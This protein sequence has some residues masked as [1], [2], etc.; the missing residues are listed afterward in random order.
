MTAML[1]GNQPNKGRKQSI[2]FEL[3]YS[4]EQV[5]KINTV[6]E[7]AQQY[8]GVP[9]KVLSRK[10]TEYWTVD[11]LYATLVSKG[12]DPETASQIAT[13]VVFTPIVID[14]IAWL[15]TNAVKAP[16]TSESLIPLLFF[17]P[18]CEYSW[19][20]L[21]LLIKGVDPDLLKKS[22]NQQCDLLRGKIYKLLSVRGL[23]LKELLDANLS[24]QVASAIR[25]L[26]SG[27][28]EVPLALL[29]ET[30]QT[31]EA[32]ESGK[33]PLIKQDLVN[34]IEEFIKQRGTEP[35]R[36]VRIEGGEIASLLKREKPSI[37][38]LGLLSLAMD[39]DQ[40]KINRLAELT[41][42]LPPVSCQAIVRH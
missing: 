15:G 40:D 39:E 33:L 22:L 6:L 8:F 26:M 36:E 17:E 13:T 19:D 18:F 12:Y 14:R 11:R 25:S 7:Q 9:R 3:F 10:L 20:E 27:S 37:T 16:K 23:D 5:R 21:M 41:H 28:D 31:I 4:Q 42:W 34:A 35:F 32:I 24:P 38:M 2:A 1:Q 30:A 29:D